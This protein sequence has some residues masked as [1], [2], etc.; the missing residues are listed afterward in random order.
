MST[1]IKP[2]YAKRFGFIAVA[3]TLFVSVIVLLSNKPSVIT[4]NSKEG[5]ETPYLHTIAMNTNKAQYYPNETVTVGFGVLDSNGDII[6]DADLILKVISPSGKVTKYLTKDLTIIVN[7]SQCNTKEYMLQNDYEAFVKTGEIGIYKLQLSVKKD[8]VELN[9]ESTFETTEN[10]LYEIE[11]LAPT[12]VYPIMEY[13]V[14]IKIKANQNYSGKIVEYVPENFILKTDEEEILFSNSFES[15]TQEQQQLFLQNPLYGTSKRLNDSNNVVEWDVDLKKGDTLTLFYAFDADDISPELY[16]LDGLEIGDFVESRKWEVAIDHVYSTVD[17]SVSTV[18]QNNQND[19]RNVVFVDDYN[20]YAFYIDSG[21]QAAYSKTVNGG[22]NW[23]N[24]V[25]LTAQ[26]D[27]SNVVVWYDRW[28]PGYDGTLINVAFLENGNDI[29]YENLDIAN[30]DSQQGEVLAVNRST[31]GHTASTD[32]LSITVGTDGKIYIAHQSSIASSTSG[33]VYSTNGTDWSDAAQEGLDDATADFVM[34]TPLA[35][36]DVMLVRWDVSADDIQ[37]K[38]YDSSAN[39]WSE[40]WA[41]ID[42]N[43]IDD[44]NASAANPH[45]KTWGVL[46]NPINLNVYIAYVDNAGLAAATPDIRTAIF[47]GSTWTNKTDVITDTNSIMDVA[48]GFD[49]NSGDVYVSYLRG[50]SDTTNNAYYKI[51]TDAMTSWSLERGK[52]TIL[53][54]DGKAIYMNLISSETFGLVVH[55]DDDNDDFFGT[56]ADVGS[57]S[58]VI[59]LTNMVGFEGGGFVDALST[60]G[61]I[62]VQSSIARSGDYALRSNPANTTGY[63]EYTGLYAAT[64]LPNTTDVDNIMVQFALRIA[65]AP[66]TN[67]II[68][69]PDETSARLQITLRTDRTL[70]LNTN[71]GDGTGDYAMSLDT[72]Y[73]I[74]LVMDSDNDLVEV[75]IYDEDMRNILDYM[76]GTITNLEDVDGVRYGFQT[77]CRGDIYID[78]ILTYTDNVV[79]N[80]PLIEGNVHI[81][82]MDLDGTGTETGWTGDYTAIDEIPPDA[83]DYIYSTTISDETSNLESAE[84]AGISG[85]V[86]EVKVTNTIWEATAQTSTGIRAVRTLTPLPQ[87]HLPLT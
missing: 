59:L 6:C 78:D 83:G 5:S 44:P 13:P 4:T 46:T 85:D 49:R 14:G 43:A 50:S 71:T 37:S 30:S 60:S 52:L 33:L 74:S 21:G 58:S 17:A 69:S 62:D 23:S 8:G 25:L 15:L 51:S 41:D 79:S 40:S 28:T 39:T 82:R 56:V 86:L 38:I 48:I 64:G 9:K 34:V 11:R 42:T 29:Y 84:S 66:S 75:R 81:N 61:T 3:I 16:R 35:D 18:A 24:P 19:G 31:S 53:E 2:T 72:W 47:N 54:D 77:S 7:Q 12:R 27:C 36:A 80:F 22:R 70:S 32:D 20:A 45:R 65:S 10:I 68:W 73:T 87:K 76:Y 57:V 67:A 26:T 55:D 1:K 63:A